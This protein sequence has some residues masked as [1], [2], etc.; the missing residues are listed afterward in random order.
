MQRATRESPRERTLHEQQQ[1]AKHIGSYAAAVAQN[2]VAVGEDGVT[3]ATATQQAIECHP[4]RQIGFGVEFH[5]RSVSTV[6]EHAHVLR[7]HGGERI[8]RQVC[9]SVGGKSATLDGACAD[10]AATHVVLV[11]RAEEV[12]RVEEGGG[13]GGRIADDGKMEGRVP[14]G[15]GVEALL[16]Q[17][18]LAL[19]QLPAKHFAGDLD[20]ISGGKTHILLGVDERVVE[21]GRDGRGPFL[22][23]LHEDVLDR[24]FEEHQ[25]GNVVLLLGTYSSDD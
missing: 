21:D 19:Q 15:E 11:L 20:V 13:L 3:V 23:D 4:K 2:V 22:A 9:R 12:Y 10:D 17:D 5:S 1:N 24:R 7:H 14:A 16:V 25:A 18:Q 6:A 8:G